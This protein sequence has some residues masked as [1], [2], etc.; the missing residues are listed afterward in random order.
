M[1]NHILQNNCLWVTVNSKGAELTS[2]KN[3]RGQELLWQ[4]DK[5]IWPRHAPVL[6][7]I[8]GKL[9]DN[10]YTYNNNTY[11]LSQ[12]GFARDKEF[13]LVEQSESALR[14]ELTANEKTLTIYPFHFSLIITYVLNENSLEIICKVFNPDNKLLYY[15]IGA[16]PGFSTGIIQ[17]ESLS[18]YVLK[19]EGKNELLIE[20][21]KD[22]LLSG[23]TYTI[24]LTNGRLPLN[25]KLF[26][27]DALVC[28]N[29]QIEKVKLY[30]AKSGNAIEMICKDW[31]YFGIWTKKGCDQF[32]CLEPW[33]G[34]TD[35]MN[36]N[37]KF[38][39]KEGIKNLNP[40]EYNQFTYKINVT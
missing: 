9:K 28:K 23:E 20:K 22:G 24:A 32:V 19:F 21:L 17:G 18:D 6:F 36:H 29:T 16:H 10:L 4:A 27:N 33:Q 31:P 30:S 3:K 35:S 40:Y 25:V 26:D 13:V 34:I 38:E 1:S 37:T 5:D 39:M 12:H 11:T 2:L 8:V 15:S 7:P 14:F